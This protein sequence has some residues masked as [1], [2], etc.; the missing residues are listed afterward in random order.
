MMETGIVRELSLPYASPL[1]VVKKKDGSNRM[2]VD[3]QKLNLVT[4]ADT[5]PMITAED[6]FGK[7]RKCQYYSTIDLSKGYWQIPVAEE[8]VLKT[9]FVTPD[10][11]YK[12]L[13]TGPD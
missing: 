1:V 4:V 9:A 11:C 2:C 12:L 7:L 13:R 10:G 5:A 3:Y 6:L 8:D